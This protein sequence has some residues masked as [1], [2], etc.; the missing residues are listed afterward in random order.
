[1]D[2]GRRRLASIDFPAGE[3]A[4]LSACI[5][6]TSCESLRGLISVGIW[7]GLV[8]LINAFP[9]TASGF[10]WSSRPVSTTVCSPRSTKVRLFCGSADPTDGL[11][12]E[13]ATQPGP[14]MPST[15]PT[16]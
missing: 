4:E 8:S 13:A 11:R 2:E 15:W 7:I 12:A 6:A 3:A 1:M 14:G 10:C 16:H 9:H 5:P